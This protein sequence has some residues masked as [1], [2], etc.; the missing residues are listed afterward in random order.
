MVGDEIIKPEKNKLISFEGNKIIHS[1]N[2]ITE[3][4]RYTIPCWYRIKNV[5]IT[6]N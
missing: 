4:E 3:G 2:T 1:V 6:W 5:K